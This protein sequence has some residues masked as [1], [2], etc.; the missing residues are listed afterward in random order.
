MKDTGISDKDPS[1]NKDFCPVFCGSVFVFLFWIL[2]ILLCLIYL[3]YIPLFGAHG[4]GTIVPEWQ[5]MKPSLYIYHLV[6]SVSPALA[7]FIQV[8]FFWGA[9]LGIYLGFRVLSEKNALDAPVR[10]RIFDAVC[11]DPGIS[12]NVLRERTGINRGTLR[13]HIAVLITTRKITCIRDGVFSRY[14]PNR[15]EISECDKLVACR[16]QGGSDRAILTYLYQSTPSS[17]HEIAQAVGLSP[18]VVSWR[19]QRLC[20][21]GIV[22]IKRQGRVTLIGLSCDAADAIGRIQ[23]IRMPEGSPAC[24]GQKS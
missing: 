15:C 1:Q 12:F 6:S 2:V 13:Y 16:F 17:Q 14:L 20:Q 21:E 9:G 19:V 8:I 22:T 7:R 23:F 18:S 5:V 4:D 10:S 11:N 3:V 24:I